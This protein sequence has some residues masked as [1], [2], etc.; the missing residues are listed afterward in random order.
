MRPLRRDTSWMVRAV[1][2]AAKQT[3]SA[4]SQAVA[5]SLRAIRWPPLGWPARWT[6]AWADSGTAIADLRPCG[7]VRAGAGAGPVRSAEWDDRHMPVVHDGVA[8]VTGSSRGLGAVIARR[9]ARDGLA[10]A[11]N[12][13]RGDGQGRTG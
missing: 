12:G 3:S 5:G 9:L 2:R 6:T 4:L 8:L 13:R 7:L 1:I 11:V 10:V